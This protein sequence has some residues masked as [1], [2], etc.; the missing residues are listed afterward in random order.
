MGE[1]DLELELKIFHREAFFMLEVVIKGQNQLRILVFP[2]KR[3][4]FG[5]FGGFEIE[6]LDVFGNVGK[7]LC[8][9]VALVEEE[10]CHHILDGLD[11]SFILGE[12]GFLERNSF[13]FVFGFKKFSQ[14]LKFCVEVLVI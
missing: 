14:N 11:Y 12:K 10:L 4:V 8:F 2:E 6:T 9:Y 1:F 7:R 5:K 3:L 13:L